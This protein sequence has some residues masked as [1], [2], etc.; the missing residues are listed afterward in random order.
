MSIAYPEFRA[1]RCTRYRF[2]YSECRRCEDACPHEAI[3]L[4]DEGGAIDAARCQNCALCVTACP[5][6]ALASGGF[7]PVDM[8]RQAIR[9]DRFTIACAPSGAVAD[10]VVP[11]LG[12][13]DA[14]SLAYL[15]K[16]RIPV[17]MRGASHCSECAHGARGAARLAL[18]LDAC[19]VLVRAAGTAEAPAD[20]IAPEVEW[21]TTPSPTI[22]GGGRF[23][24]S[25]RQWFR[26]LVGRGADE[27]MQASG[28]SVAPL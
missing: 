11:C 17:T 19:E 2:R 6:D 5:T 9:Q 1:S 14:A 18:H 3:A 12:A 27:V 24:A 21:A 8:L 22:A 20:W 25:R 13:V 15:A 26:R 23:V 4:S 16:R 10:A 7:K 28:P